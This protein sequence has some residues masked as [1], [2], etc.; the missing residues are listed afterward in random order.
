MIS[1][2]SYKKIYL[3]QSEQYQCIMAVPQ[4]RERLVVAIVQGEVPFK[5]WCLPVKVLDPVKEQLI[6]AAQSPVSGNVRAR[7][8]L[9]VAV[10]QGEVPFKGCC[11]PVKMLDP[12]KEQLITAA[13]SPA[14]G[15]VRTRERFAGRRTLGCE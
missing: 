4:T 6:T 1:K 11:L 9:V 8:C 5:G 3:L 14:S 7:E 12:V 13:Q 15:N 10:V 2:K